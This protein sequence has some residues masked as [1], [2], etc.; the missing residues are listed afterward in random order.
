[1]G[2][3]AKEKRRRIGTSKTFALK[4]GG[5]QRHPLRIGNFLT[6]FYWGWTCS[7]STRL[8]CSKLE[9]WAHGLDSVSKERSQ[10]KP[11]Q[12]KTPLWP[13]AT[14]HVPETLKVIRFTAVLLTAGSRLTSFWDVHETDLSHCPS[15]FIPNAGRSG[16]SSFYRAPTNPSPPPPFLFLDGTGLTWYHRGVCLMHTACNWVRESVRGLLWH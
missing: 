2:K 7:T 1:M 3:L 13:T 5:I 14:H 8:I 9:G 6:L 4:L 16:K 11:T 15:Y 12:A 10:K